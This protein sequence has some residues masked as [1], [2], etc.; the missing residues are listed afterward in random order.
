MQPRVAMRCLPAGAPGHGLRLPQRVRGP[1]GRAA[2]GRGVVCGTPR[3][4]PGLTKAQR[5]PLIILID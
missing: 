4:W 2:A 5:S 3:H 1:S